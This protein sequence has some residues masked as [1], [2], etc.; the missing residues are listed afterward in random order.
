MTVS[1][2]PALTLFLAGLMA[3]LPW[4]LD[5]SSRTVVS[6]VPV[7]LVH[8]WSLRQPDGL[9]VGYIFV[10]G[11]LMDLLGQGPVGYWALL[12]LVAAGSARV[13][14]VAGLHDTSL[15]RAV[16][17]V[18]AMAVT[19]AVGWSLASLYLARALDPHPY[20]LAVG[21]LVAVYPLGALLLMP[22]N[23]YGRPAARA[24]FTRGT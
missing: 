24:T 5:A 21:V 20:I 19:T 12:M 3:V 13:A 16:N 4:G 14:A 22:L 23:R 1:V 15:S 7:A 2:I 10:L 9:P 11:V 17:F 8:Y 18:I 6:F